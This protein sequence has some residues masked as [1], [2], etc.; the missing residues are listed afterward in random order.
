MSTTEIESI[1]SERVLNMTES[2]TLQMAAM[3]RKMKEQGIDVITLSLGEPDFDTPQHIKDAALKAMQDGHTKYTAVAGNLDLREAIVAKLKRE[4]GL[5]FKPNQIVVSNGAKQDIA[6]LCMALLN[7]GDEVI[8]LS[9]YWVSYSDIVHM[10]GGKAVLLSASVDEDFKVPASKVAAAITSRTKL[11]MF[12][13]PCNPS[14]SV[15]SH[16]E[17][18]AIAEVVAPHKN[19]YIMSDEIY[20]HITFSGQHVSIASF[21]EVKERTVVING[22][23]KAFAMTGW[24]LGYMAAPLFIAEACTKIQGQ[25]T[26]GANSIAQKAGV[27]ALN[28][29]LQPTLDMTAAFKKRRDL[30]ISLLKDIPGFK[31]NFPTGAFYIFPDISYYFGKTDGQTVINNSDDFALFL[32]HHAHVATV[33]GSAFGDDNCFRISYAASEQNIE[34]AVR[35]IKKAVTTLH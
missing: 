17:L 10:F 19:I 34:E 31:C 32:L 7:P 16:S 29:D 12:S 11:I 25:I 9:P 33:G 23:S 35:R 4:N 26:S 2:A 5:D 30:I 14:G 24:R 18:K 8:I 28:S 15:F 6:N 3:A 13:S 21:P 22:F 20:E 1:L 27:A